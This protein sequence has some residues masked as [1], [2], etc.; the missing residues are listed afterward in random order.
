MHQATRHQVG[1]RVVDERLVDALHE[2]R[3]EAIDRDFTR[4]ANLLL[5]GASWLAWVGSPQ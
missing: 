1:Q 5:N 3:L 4:H 2:R